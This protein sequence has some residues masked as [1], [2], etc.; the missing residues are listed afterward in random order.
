[1]TKW[2]HGYPW[3][4]IQTNLRETDMADIDANDYVAQLKEFQATVAMI[5]TSGII[6]SYESD[7]DF[8]FQSEF[9][10]GDGLER[11]IEACH[12]AGIRV[13]ART[14]FSKVRR[15][16]YEKHPEW[17]YRTADGEIVDYNGDVHVCM[18]GEYQ[19][20]Y[21][22]EIIRET[23][24]KLAVDG[25]FFNMGGYQERDYSGNY[26]GFC[27]CAACRRRFAEMYG[28][29]IPRVADPDDQ[30]Y[31]SYLKFKEVT[32]EEYHRKLEQFIH[33][34]RPDMC[35]DRAFSLGEGFVRQESNTAIARPL[36]RW[37][38]SASDNTKWVVGSYPGFVSSNTSVDFIDFP[39]RHVAVSPAQ[40][41]LR[42]AQSLANG[43]VL[44]YYLIGRLD[45]HEDR[46][47][48]DEIKS[49]F[50]FHAEHE[51]LFSDMRSKANVLLVKDG[52]GDEA[53]YRG[54]YR[55][56][57]ES[58]FLFDTMLAGRLE[59]N[60]LAGYELVIL[61]NTKALS[62]R[63]CEKL[64]ALVASGGRVI[65]VFDSASWD[66]ELR[67]RAS[68][69][70]KSLGIRRVLHR[71]KEMTSSY[72]KI[73]AEFPVTALSGT[74]LVY[75]DGPYDY[76]EYEPSCTPMLKLIPPHNFGPPERCYYTQVTDH[77]GLVVHGHGEGAAIHIPWLPG[78]LFHR[79]GYVNTSN[80]L[81]DL[82]RNV[83]AIEPLGGDLSPMVEATLFEKLDGSSA[84]L[85]LVN[86]S[87]HFGTSFYH[88]VEIAAATITVPCPEKPRSVR[89]EV[90]DRDLSHSWKD[91]RL[92]LKVERLG[93]FDFV[94]IVH[95]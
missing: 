25:V 76:C 40:Q 78:T 11:I 65:S 57:T 70:L 56:L 14:D 4:M 34:I 33:S 64:D 6:A 19:Q 8:H 18:N 48:Y 80:F 84:R 46:T 20:V 3:R 66:D 82:V 90:L 24:E 1:M 31:R 52:Y 26:Y 42:L 7:L 68:A 37:Q 45:D 53:E 2:W 5:N 79:Q 67:V 85:S 10:H 69:G 28:E 55:T 30:V 62:D 32:Q 81:S 23:L 44:D 51:E 89:S 75:L 61:P 38:Y 71:R 12:A 63:S 39:Y 49:V 60:E 59:E 87:G 15:P 17:A 54:W 88:P 41:S 13:I 86:N 35:I 27:H 91:G 21:A 95:A 22:L 16:I 43:G 74:S 58:H 93:L 73:G 94:S 72:F 83:A 29:P 36:P 9:L 92:E 47:G 77:P 50:A